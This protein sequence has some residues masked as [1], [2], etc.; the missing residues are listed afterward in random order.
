[1]RY[2]NPVT[3]ELSWNKAW[4]FLED[5]VQYVMVSNISLATNRTVFSVLD[6]KRSSGQVHEETLEDGS[7][8][9]WHAGVG[10]VVPGTEGFL[11]KQKMETRQGNWSAIGTSRVP[12]TQ[13]KMFTATIEHKNISA[14]LGYWVFPGV[15]DAQTFMSKA[16]SRPIS[17]LASSS[18]VSAIYDKAADRSEERRVGKECRN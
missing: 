4:F 17:T 18:S 11:L 8:A 1:M 15:E 16:V 10:Y 5:D 7:T 2:T 9:L 14:P 13:V 3:R 12:S 6:Q